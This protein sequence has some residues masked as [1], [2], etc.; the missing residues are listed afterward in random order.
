MVNM[1][2]ASVA[3][4]EMTTADSKTIDG[5]RMAGKSG[6]AQ[7]ADQYG[8]YNGG[9]TGSYVAVAPAEDP[10]ILVYVVID[11]PVNGYYGGTVA[12]PTARQMMMQALPRYGIAPSTDVPAYTD[13]LTY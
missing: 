9:Y 6:T 12:F 11:E 5:Y 4:P 13:P 3:S 10:Q 1:M 2:E 8:N 7:K